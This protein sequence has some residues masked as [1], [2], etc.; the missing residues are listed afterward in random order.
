MKFGRLILI[1]LLGLLTSPLSA[2]KITMGAL[3]EYLNSLKTLQANF[4]QISSDS[5]LSTGTL[6][7][8]RPG[9]VRFEYDPPNNALVLASSGQLAIFDP[10]GN[11]EPES[12]PLSK[13]PLSLILA[14][15]ITLAEDRMVTS[16][17]YDGT[18]TILTVQDPDFPERGTIRLVFTGPEPQL[19]QW[20]IQD[21][22]GEQTVVVLNDMKTQLS[23]SEGLFDILVNRKKRQSKN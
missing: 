6:Y 4:T 19:R 10:K 20:L 21:Q 1:L 7:I 16:H 3:S 22:N 15:S 13:T 9:R 18:S 17:E 12:Y 23:L 14:D 2:E 11:A 5:N 8:K